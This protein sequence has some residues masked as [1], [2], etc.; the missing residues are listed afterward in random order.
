[1]KTLNVYVAI[2][3]CSCFF[4]CEQK[5]Q[6]EFSIEGDWIYEFEMHSEQQKEYFTFEYDYC[7]NKV[8]WNTTKGYLINHDTLSL[9]TQKHAKYTIELLKENY[10]ELKPVNNDADWIDQYLNGHPDLILKLNRILKKNDFSFKRIGFSSS[11]CNG[12]CASMYLEIDSIGNL[13]F[14]GNSPWIKES[15]GPHIGKIS[16]KKLAMIIR[17]AQ[18]IDFTEELKIDSTIYRDAH[19]IGLWFET[20]DDTFHISSVNHFGKLPIEMFN[21]SNMLTEL[22]KHVDL[23]KDT[24][25]L[26]RFQFLSERVQ[27][28]NSRR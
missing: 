26:N 5:S 16:S 19:P 3:L 7:S 6:L 22:Y 10:L 20:N 21:F 27:Y 2:I 25:I 12:S 23:K 1:M 18:T 4:S 9:G 28:I 11:N 17:K 24:T 8:P 13:I 15:Y 14:Y